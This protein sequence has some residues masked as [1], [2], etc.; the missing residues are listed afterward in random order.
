MGLMSKLKPKI[1]SGILIV[2]GLP[3]EEDENSYGIGRG[4][5]V[6]TT[7]QLED[8]LKIYSP[9]R[10]LIDIARAAEPEINDLAQRLKRE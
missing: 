3:T 7:Q 6:P 5:P 8:R 10:Y 1:G 2:L 9:K 4:V